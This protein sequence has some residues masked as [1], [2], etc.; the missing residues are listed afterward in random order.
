MNL[1]EIETME[2]GPQPLDA[3]LSRL[4]L[5]NHALVE[6]SSEHLTH[7]VVQKARKGRKVTRNAQQKILRALNAATGSNH[8]MEEIFNYRGR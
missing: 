7:K 5:P 8:T 6:N 3:L 4:A 1:V 2:A